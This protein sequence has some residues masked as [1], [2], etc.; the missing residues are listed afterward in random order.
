MSDIDR[1]LIES[2]Y[3]RVGDLLHFFLFFFLLFIYFCAHYCFICLCGLVHKFSEWFLVSVQILVYSGKLLSLILF[4]TAVFVCRSTCVSVLSVTLSVV[5]KA[6]RLH[7]HVVSRLIELCSHQHLC[8]CTL[9]DL[10]SSS[11]E[12]I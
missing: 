6:Y 7:R 11:S 2:H 9:R 12:Y 3:Y 10:E 5:L 8:M 1:Q 4:I